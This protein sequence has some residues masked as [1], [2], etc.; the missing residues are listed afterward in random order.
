VKLGFLVLLV[1]I[2]I[3]LFYI[4]TT[5]NTLSIEL[6]HFLFLVNPI[7]IPVFGFL[8]F[9]FISIIKCKCENRAMVSFSSLVGAN[10]IYL[11]STTSFN[12]VTIM[13]CKITKTY[14]MTF[15]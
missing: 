15:Y 10:S 14:G 7:F 9:D 1:D 6:T 8:E 2:P 4:L 11:T 13:V 12:M 3:L 5:T